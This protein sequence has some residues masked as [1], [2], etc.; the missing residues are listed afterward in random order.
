MQFY[1]VFKLNNEKISLHILYLEYVVLID[2]LH[3][4]R[5]CSAYFSFLTEAF[6]CHVHHF[7]CLTVPVEPGKPSSIENDAHGIENLLLKT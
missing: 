1:G 3:Y 7:Q 4:A 2:S 6:R 5:T